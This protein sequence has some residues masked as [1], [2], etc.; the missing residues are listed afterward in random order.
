MEGDLT[1]ACCLTTILMVPK[2][3][4]IFQ[5]FVKCGTT[6]C[7]VIIDNGSCIDA[8]TSKLVSLLDLKLVA[9]PKPYKVSWVDDS[10]I[11]IK[12]RCLVPIHILLYKAQISCD[13]IPMDV[14][15]I[16]LGRPWLYDLDVTLYG[17]LN[18]CS[19]MHNGQRIKLNP[20]KTKFVSASKA[21]EEPKRQSINL[22]SP[23]ELERAVNQDSIIFALVV[24]EVALDNFEE[25]RKEVRSL[26]QEFQDV[27]LRSFQI[28]CLLCVIFNTP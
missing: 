8:V 27:S 28:S 24:K 3:D 18:S 6:N 1:I 22:I 2:V 13:V 16:I 11:T 25:P 4:T 15:H 23:K 5:T 21:R 19:F 26:L 20:I 14:G 17:R 12:G 10:F 7:K 9:H